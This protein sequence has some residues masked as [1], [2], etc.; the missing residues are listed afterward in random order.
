MIRGN[1][2]LIKV[3]ICA[4]LAFVSFLWI[5]PF[6]WMI[7]ASFKTTMELFQN[8]LKL[9]P[10]QVSFESYIGHGLRGTLDAIP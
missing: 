8:G 10:Q 9:V 6:L 2:T 5:Y 3:C 4:F 1:R 7:S